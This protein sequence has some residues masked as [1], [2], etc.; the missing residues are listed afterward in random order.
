MSDPSDV[1]RFGTPL[2][3]AEKA[4]IAAYQ[5]HGTYKEAAAALRKSPRT[6]QHQLATARIRT[7]SGRSFQI[8]DNEA[9]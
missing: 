2:T 1:A 9:A 6:I 3:P 8:R 7:G 5:R 4:A